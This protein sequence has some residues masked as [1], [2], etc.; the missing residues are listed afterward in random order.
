MPATRCERFAEEG[1]RPTIG[2]MKLGWSGFRS[3]FA[4]AIIAVTSAAEANSLGGGGGFWALSCR[5]IAAVTNRVRIVQRIR[6]RIKPPVRRRLYSIRISITQA[7]H[8][9]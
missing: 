6:R 1:A 5:A 4:F 2:W 7:R 3:A 9:R 8:R